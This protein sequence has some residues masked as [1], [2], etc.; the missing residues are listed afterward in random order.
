MVRVKI[1][2]LTRAQDAAV[3]I[4]AGADALGFILWPGS[5]RFLAAQAVRAILA[6]LPPLVTSVGVFVNQSVEEVAALRAASGV[7]V[8]Q[9]A[10]DEPPEHVAALAPGVIKVF[11]SAPENPLLWPA[12]AWLA[13]GAAP[14]QYGGTGHSAGDAVV[15]ALAPTGRLILAGGLTPATVAE[16]VQRWRPYAVDVASG[17]ET[18]PGIKD[19]ELIRQFIAAAKQA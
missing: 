17:V 18:A 19:H 2:G 12:Q 1:C 16:R 4:A 14:G 9:L 7:Q 15:A 11:R 5:K 6:E 13:D 10:G 3:A 8:V